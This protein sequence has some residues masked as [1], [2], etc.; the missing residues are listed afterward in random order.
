LPIRLVREDRAGLSNARNKGVAEA[1]G[2]YICW[3]D[4]DVVLDPEWLA[5]YWAAFKRHPE[6]A[7]F[8]GRIEPILQAPTPAWFEK[9][10]GEWP[11]NIL[12]AMRD[13]GDESRRLDFPSGVIPFGANFAIRTAEQR[14]VLYEPGL[15]VS[16]N[17]RRVGEEAEVIFRLLSGGAT[18]WWVPGSKVSHIIS[19]E[20]Q[21]WD[22]IYDFAQAYGE[23]LAF[24][25]HAWPGDHHLASSRDRRRIGGLPAALQLRAALYHAASRIARLAGSDRRGAQFLATAGLFSGAHRFAGKAIE[26]MAA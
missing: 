6:A 15:G 10:R 26:P 14:R 7:I 25:E 21:T 23:T 1:A 5:G 22:Y 11:V 8:G 12:L 17:H 13:F 19:T 18:G 2:R 16:P 24:M 3:T 4:D 9:L 20:R